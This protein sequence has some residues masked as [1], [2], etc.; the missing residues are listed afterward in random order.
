LPWGDESF[1]LVTQFTCLSSVL[2]AELRADIAAEM[3]RVLAPGGVVLSFDMHAAPWPIRAL[4]GL[5]KL[6]LR[7]RLPSGGTPVDPLRTAELESWFPGV[8][9]RSVGLD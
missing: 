4:R 6:Y 1:T 5:V 3:W 8:R 9:R 2:D 7:G